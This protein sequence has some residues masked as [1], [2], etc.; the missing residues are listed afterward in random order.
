MGHFSIAG[1]RARIGWTF[2]VV[3]L[4]S[5]VVAARAEAHPVAVA[6]MAEVVFVVAL[7]QLG[8]YA[9]MAPK[10][11]LELELSGMGRW[12]GE[13]PLRVL[14]GGMAA[15]LLLALGAGVALVWVAGGTPG[16]YV[17]VLM[18]ADIPAA[19]TQS[20]TPAVALALAYVARVSAL[21]ALV[22]TLP[23]Y[24]YDCGKAL[25]LLT[26]SSRW[27]Y[28]CG[29]LLAA[30]LALAALVMGWWLVGFLLLMRGLVNYVRA[31]L[32]PDEST[33]RS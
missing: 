28:I 13:K 25:I 3:A 20:C 15:V 23:L 24:P 2:W 26:G 4:L 29:M 30:A 27:V 6:A 32:D 10:E 5:G 18:E 11:G 31:Y 9:L 8:G 17:R 7:V 21:W 16:L 14:A 33:K 19:L 1:V 22:N 12:T